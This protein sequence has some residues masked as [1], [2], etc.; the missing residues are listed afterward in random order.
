MAK[1]TIELS[2]EVVQKIKYWRG[3]AE[4]RIGKPQGGIESIVEDMVEETANVWIAHLEYL[5]S[6]TGEGE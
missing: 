1:Y 3:E 4:K 2:D 6:E 5:E